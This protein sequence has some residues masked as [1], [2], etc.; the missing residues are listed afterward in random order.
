MEMKG[1]QTALLINF[2]L[3]E[4]LLYS[5]LFSGLGFFMTNFLAFLLLLTASSKSPFQK[6]WY[7]ALLPFGIDFSAALSTVLVNLVC[8][9]ST[10][11][12]K[13]KLENIPFAIV[14]NSF[15]LALESFHAVLLVGFLIPFFI[16]ME[17][18]I[19]R[20]SLPKSSRTFQLHWLCRYAE[21]KVWSGLVHA[22]LGL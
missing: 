13:S 19:G 7:L 20:W 21:I 22:P 14:L 4:S 16:E 5:L 10:S 18:R 15:Q 2:T 1:T 8:S 3:A 11:S 9:L 6:T 17:I 12:L